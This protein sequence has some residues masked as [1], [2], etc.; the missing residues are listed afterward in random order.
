MIL[1][2]KSQITQFYILFVVFIV[3]FGGGGS[4]AMGGKPMPPLSLSLDQ[5]ALPNGKRE[6]MFRAVANTSGHNVA[7]EIVLP[8]SVILIEGETRWEGALSVSEEKMLR[9]TVRPAIT[10]PIRIVGEATLY[11]PEGDTMVQKSAVILNVPKEK[12]MPPPK[13]PVLKKQGHQTIL[14]FEGK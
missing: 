12:P 7:L 9:V 14:E 8:P 5:A 6:L 13:P 3:L 11:F 4:Y 2:E 1:V 10:D